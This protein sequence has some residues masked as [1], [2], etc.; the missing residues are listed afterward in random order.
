MSKTNVKSH[1]NG[2]RPDGEGQRDKWQ[3]WITDDS[4]NTCDHVIHIG[5]D[6]NIIYIGYKYCRYVVF[7]KETYTRRCQS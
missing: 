6:W 5:D 2:V 4:E 3:L 7:D 1:S